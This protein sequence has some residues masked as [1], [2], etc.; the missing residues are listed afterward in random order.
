MVFVDTSAIYAVLDRD[1]ENHGPAATTW[2]RLLTSAVPMLTH[3]YELVETAALVQHRLGVAALRAVHENMA[4][5]LRIEWVRESQHRI[6]ME[7]VIMAGGR[8]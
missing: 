7:M 3:N 5:V 8:N 4:P 2:E 1:D 6:A